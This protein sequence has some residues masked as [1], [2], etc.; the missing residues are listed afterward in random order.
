MASLTRGGGQVGYGD[1]GRTKGGDDLA[2]GRSSTRVAVL[3][4]LASFYEPCEGFHVRVLRP[5]LGFR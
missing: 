5:E 3:V 4:D 1:V 2:E